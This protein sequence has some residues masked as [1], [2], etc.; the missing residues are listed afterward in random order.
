MLLAALA[1]L[2]FYVFGLVMGVF[3][4]FEIVALTVVAALAI[5]GIAMVWLRERLRR[6]PSAELEEAATQA[7]FERERRGF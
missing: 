3:S 4:P 7:R 5:A 2:G 1:Y 6:D